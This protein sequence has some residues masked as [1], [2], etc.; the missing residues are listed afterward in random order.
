MNLELRSNT[1]I[2]GTLI[3][4][5]DYFPLSPKVCEAF[6]CLQCSLGVGLIL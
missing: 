6:L 1:L 3:L 2:T 4:S 5:G